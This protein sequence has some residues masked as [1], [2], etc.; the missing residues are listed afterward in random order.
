MFLTLTLRSHG[1]GP[2]GSAH[3]AMKGHDLVNDHTEAVLM[4]T[5]VT[6]PSD[7]KSKNCNTGFNHYFCARPSTN[8]N[9][10]CHCKQALL[11]TDRLDRPPTYTQTSPPAR[12]SLTELTPVREADH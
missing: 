4:L 8:R 3:T 12:A 10:P 5:E 1:G 7:E 2:C 11:K 6:R 9:I